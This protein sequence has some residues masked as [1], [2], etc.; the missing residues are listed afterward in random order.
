[1]LS[2]NILI[3]MESGQNDIYYRFKV[4]LRLQHG[5]RLWLKVLKDQ[6]KEHSSEDSVHSSLSFLLVL[7]AGS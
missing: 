6:A 4:V 3:G 5:E 2:R 7:L 1:M